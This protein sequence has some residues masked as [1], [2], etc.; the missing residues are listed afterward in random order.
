MAKKEKTVSEGTWVYY[1]GS[2]VTKHGYMRVV[3]THEPYHKIHEND[4]VRYMLMYGPKFTQ[5]VENAR[6]ESFTVVSKKTGMP[7]TD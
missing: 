2:L 6:R 3:G 4:N 7:K 5:F 1:H